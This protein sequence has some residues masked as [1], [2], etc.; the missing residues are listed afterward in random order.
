[1]QKGFVLWLTGLS[2]SGK[3]TLGDRIE[4]ELKQK[5][6]L[7]ERL[8]GDLIRKHLWQ[9]L[10]FAKEDR[11]EHIRRAGFLA[12]L[13]S[14]NGI[15][16]IASFISPYRAEREG[17]RKQAQNFIEVFC[18][19][20]LDVCKQRDE[21]GLYEK[22]ERGEIQNFTGVSDPYELPENPE[23]ELHTDTASIEENTQKILDYLKEHGY[24]Q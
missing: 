19:C 3:T 23:I 13:L 10:G 17:A 5:G 6:Y 18:N 12:A 20:P 1:M 15:G 16:V 2:G 14:R 21:K 22:A 11:D 8:D 4:K 7:A 24:I 9:D